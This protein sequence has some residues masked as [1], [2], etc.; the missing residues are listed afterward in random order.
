MKNFCHQF[1]FYQLLIQLDK[2]KKRKGREKMKSLCVSGGLCFAMTPCADP[3][4]VCPRLHPPLPF[5]KALSGDWLPQAACSQLPESLDS[6]SGRPCWETEG[7]EEGRSRGVSPMSAPWAGPLAVAVSLLWLRCHQATFLWFHFFWVT[8]DPGPENTIP[9]LC[10]PIL[11][12][13]QQLLAV[14]NLWV[15]SL[16]LAWFLAFL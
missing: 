11:G 2:G 9:F 14:V 16:F 12:P 15:T 3:G 10:P 8:P 7:Q 13:G 6:V 4:P 5:W 1:G